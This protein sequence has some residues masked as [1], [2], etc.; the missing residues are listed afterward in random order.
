MKK[1]QIRIADFIIGVRNNIILKSRLTIKSVIV[2]FFFF[3]RFIYIINIYESAFYAGV[4]VHMICS[5]THAIV[6]T[7]TRAC[8]AAYQRDENSCAQQ[9][10]N[11]KLLCAERMH[12]LVIC[13]DGPHN[14][15]PWTAKIMR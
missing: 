9:L 10:H 2:D 11:T 1:Y 5:C 13:F 7:Y 3:I 4:G 8:M 6:L 15:L 14:L 12:V